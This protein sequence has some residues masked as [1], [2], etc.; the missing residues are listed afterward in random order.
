MAWLGYTMTYFTKEKSK[1]WSF[2]KYI[3]W[4]NVKG[5]KLPK[6]LI[7]FNVE[8]NLPTTKRNEL[9]FTNVLLN[10]ASKEASYFAMPKNADVVE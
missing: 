9:N 4:Q 10:D 6:R 5:L 1:K 3:D 8:N 2:I 7:W